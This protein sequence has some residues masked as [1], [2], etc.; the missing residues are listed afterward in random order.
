MKIVIDHFAVASDLLDLLKNKIT[1]FSGEAAETTNSNFPIDDVYI[2]GIL[3][4]KTGLEI[5]RPD[6]ENRV[7]EV[8][9]VK[10]LNSTSTIAEHIL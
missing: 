4:E 5:V 6:R 8:I 9:D 2:S 10:T 7:V 1:F 3:R